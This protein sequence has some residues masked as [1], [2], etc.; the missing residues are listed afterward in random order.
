MRPA[1][2]EERV[3]DFVEAERSQVPV[4]RAVASRILHAVEVSRPSPRR[5]R[6]A[7]LQVAAAVAALLLL[8]IGI[9]WMRTTSMT[10]STQSGTW[11][12]V[13]TMAIQRANHT[14]TLLPNGK[15]LVV[16]GRGLLS[17]PSPWGQPAS[18]IA[19]AELYD[20]KTRRWSSA[21]SLSVPRFG[22]TATLLSNGKV[23]V[24]G[25]NSAVPNSSYP[26]GAGS[27]SSAELYD[28]QTNSWSLAASMRNARAFHTATL[29]GDGRVLVAGGL[30]VAGGGQSSTEYPGSVLASA[31]LYDPVADTWTPTTPMPLAATSQSATLLF[32]HRALVIGGVDR[33][34]DYPI[35]SSPPIGVRAAELFDPSTNSWSLAPSMSHERISPSITL[36]PNHQVLVVGDNGPNENTAEIFDPAAEQWSPAPKPAADRA[37]HVAALLHSGAVLVAGGLGETSAELFDWRRNDWTSAGTLN[38]IRSGATA[39]VL[40]DGKVLV[41]GGFGS[42][43]IAWAGAELYD[44]QGRN[45]AGITRPRSQVLPGTLAM[46]V[47]ATAILLALGLWLLG[48][49]RMSQSQTGVTWID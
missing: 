38:L 43:A 47:A 13:S 39:T 31:E 9:G 34:L 42:G 24:A 5:P 30:V 28:P 19:S 11:S 40:G 20:P 48:R 21:G 1:T 8:G 2:I 16:G 12:S 49:R 15:V 27:L 37:G 41:A 25:G 35:G 44:P 7:Y 26:S 45:V 18:A 6:R 33:F 4:P 23:L 29:L 17:M 22:H 3:R 32:D 14:A 36:L 10:A 46:L